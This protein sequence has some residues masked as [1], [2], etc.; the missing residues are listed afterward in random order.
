VLLFRKRAIPNPPARIKLA[1]LKNQEFITVANSGPLGTL[2]SVE[3]IGLNLDMKERIS[4]RTFFVAAGLVKS[5]VGVTV[6][7]EFTARASLTKELDF[8]PLDPPIS[9]GVHAIHLVDRP[10]SRLAREFLS[11]LSD[12]LK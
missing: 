8:R 11:V 5:G 1:S 9:F 12:I 4:V 2:Y 7:D 10:P 6:L 3:T